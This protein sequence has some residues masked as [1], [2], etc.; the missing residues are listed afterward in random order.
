MSGPR[1]C[2]EKVSEIKLSMARFC[3]VKETGNNC[4]NPKCAHRKSLGQAAKALARMYRV[5]MYLYIKE[6]IFMKEQLYTGVHS[7]SS[8]SFSQR[9]LFSLYTNQFMKSLQPL[10]LL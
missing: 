7:Y 10:Y 8:C 5:C 9:S 1:E 3:L 2:S 6:K 4:I